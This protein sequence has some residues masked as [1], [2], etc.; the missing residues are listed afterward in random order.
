MPE[1]IRVDLHCHSSAS[2]GDHAPGYVA[3]QLAGAGVTWAALTDHNSL[4]G[5]ADFRSAVERRGMRCVTGVEIHARSPRG[6]VHLLGYGFDPNNQAL[7]SALKTFHRTWGAALRR[8]TRRLS[9]SNREVPVGTKCTPLEGDS[10]RREQPDTAEA[11]CLIHEAGGRVFL[12]HPLA[13]LKTTE[14]LEEFLDWLQPQGLDGIEAYY[15]LYFRSTQQE[16]SALAERRGLLTAA[17]SDFHGLHHSDGTDPG[18]EMP[19]EE[20]DRF[21]QA[22]G[23]TRESDTAMNALPSLGGGFVSA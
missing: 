15:K 14:R 12:A 13:G 20:W 9:S 16:L 7:E 11:I 18:V 6:P 10:A 8:W 2:D 17:G 1:I 3:H 22:L 19:A 5:L 23:L 21:L 4:G